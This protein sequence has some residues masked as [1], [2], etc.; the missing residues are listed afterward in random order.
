ML[1]MLIFNACYFSQFFFATSLFA[2][3]FGSRP[4]LFVLLGV[5]YCV[6]CSYMSYKNELFGWAVVGKPSTINSYILPFIVWALYYLLV[7]AVPLLM[8]AYPRELGPEVFAGIMTWRLV[9]NGG[10]IH[11]ALNELAIKGH[12]LSAERGMIGYGVSLGLAVLGLIIFFVNCDEKFDRSLFWR[13][14]TGKQQTKDCWVDE[15][16][17]KKSCKSKDEDRW[18]L[19]KRFHPIYIC[20]E[21]V[22]PWICNHLVEVYGNDEKRPEWMA[23]ESEDTFIKRIVEIYE[24]KG[25]DS[26]EVDNALT[27][28]FGRNGEDLE[29]GVEGQLTFI[30]SKK[31]FTSL[32]KTSKMNKTVKVQPLS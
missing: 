25:S 19:L 24:W 30:K 17:W 6:L 16:I 8:A 12:Y 1:G 31:S 32:G 21:E 27:T 18:L 10:V 2:E 4:P 22:T 29:K 13:L 9:T 5:E 3:A 14:R 28:L 7:C 15:R 26:V 23:G 20:F 11:L